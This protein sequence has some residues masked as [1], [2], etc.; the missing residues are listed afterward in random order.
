MVQRFQKALDA[1][2]DG[3][4]VR[5]ETQ[6][7][8]RATWSTLASAVALLGLCSCLLV[9][10]NVGSSLLGGLNT[11]GSKL[12]VEI[13]ND[14]GGTKF[15]IPTLAKASTDVSGL[16]ATP[17]A[18]VTFVYTPTPLATPPTATPKPSPS[19]SPTSS[20]TV[21]PGSAITVQASQNGAWNAGQ[22]GNI[23][24]ISTTP[25]QPNA[26]LQISLQ[27]GSDPNCKTNPDP[28]Q[29]PLDGNGQHQGNVS[30]TVPTCIPTGQT[31]TVTPTYTINGTTYTDTTNTFTAQG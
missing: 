10:S 27:F 14:N 1:F 8:F 19:P 4:H 28:V 31:V 18:T 17:V 12:K 11:S 22:M 26:T 5:W 7:S 2:I 9:A 3:F 16:G 29:V 30:F 21:T 24:Q 25:S 23:G 20:V 6:P 15:P 13:G